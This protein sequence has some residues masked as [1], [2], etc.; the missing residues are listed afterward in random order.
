MKASPALPHA[1]QQHAASP[2]VHRTDTVAMD[3]WVR[4]Q[5]V[6]PEPPA[7]VEAAVQRA[8]LWLGAVERA[9]SRFEPGGEVIALARTP[10]RPVPVSALLFA[11][12]ELAVHLARLTDGVFDPTVGGRLERRGFD[13]NYRTG[14]TIDSG[15]REIAASYRDVRLDRR[16]QTITLRR[17]L[18]LDLGAVAKGLAVDLIARELAT[19]GFQDF[20]VEAGGDVY[21]RGRN[22]AGL[23][24]QV[25]IQHPRAA[26]RLIRTVPV[27]DGA[28][29]TSGD[30]ERAAPDGTSHILDARTGRAPA[31][32][33]I[34]V[35]V[36][37]PTA[38][39]ADGL[40]TAVMLLGRERGLRLLAGQGVAGLL[41]QADG[42]VVT[43]RGFLGVTP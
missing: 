1:D 16:A 26:D 19:H 17:P 24:W 18:V 37:A 32:P 33:P 34:S 30:Y 8:L 31:E 6:S 11:A 20:S 22:A 21:A 2:G 10:D 13:R 14:A 36:L 29:C 4:V 39:A 41:V 5:V 43:T 25:G 9:T 35:S 27:S 3:T 28:V 42:T 7:T 15:L 23:P 38:M 12:T 40:S